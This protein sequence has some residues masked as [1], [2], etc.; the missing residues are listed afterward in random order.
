VLGSSRPTARGSTWGQAP[1]T[2]GPMPLFCPT[3][4]LRSCISDLGNRRGTLFLGQ[5]RRVRETA[6]PGPL[7]SPRN[8]GY[9]TALQPLLNWG[10]QFWPVVG[11]LMGNVTHITVGGTTTLP[12]S[13]NPGTGICGWGLVLT[14]LKCSNAPGILIYSTSKSFHSCSL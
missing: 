8:V 14:L 5:G 3:K 1:G 11:A 7:C 13:W 10:E 2:K 12:D 6:G 9:P 4:T